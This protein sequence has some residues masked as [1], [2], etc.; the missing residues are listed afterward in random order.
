MYPFSDDD[1]G[2]TKIL[3]LNFVIPWRMNNLNMILT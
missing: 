2:E 1:V 3:E